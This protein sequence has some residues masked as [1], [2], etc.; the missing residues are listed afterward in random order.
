VYNE[1]ALVGLCTQDYKCL[2]A[3]VM[4]CATVV[5]QKLIL[6][7]D[8]CDSGKYVKPRVTLSVGASKSDAPGVHIW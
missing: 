4:T 3:R 7:F 6:H 2:C 5:A 8:P 1:G